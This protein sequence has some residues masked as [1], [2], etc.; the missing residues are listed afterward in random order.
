M[1]CSLSNF[2]NLIWFLCKR[3]KKNKLTYSYIFNRGKKNFEAHCTFFP[4][5]TFMLPLSLS[6][7]LSHRPSKSSILCFYDT[8][9]FYH[10]PHG[11]TGHMGR[12]IAS[13]CIH[14]NNN[15]SI[16]NSNIHNSK[17][18]VSR[19]RYITFMHPEEFTFFLFFQKCQKFNFQLKLDFNQW[20]NWDYS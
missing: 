13:G 2:W 20:Q 3:Y 5:I 1:L 11:L 6:L 17:S 12:P 9:Y 15:N 4:A 8:I 7:S 18:N 19:S 10:R 16:H 14:S